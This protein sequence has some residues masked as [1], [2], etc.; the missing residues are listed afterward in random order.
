MQGDRAVQSIPKLK[1]IEDPKLLKRIRHNGYNR[2]QICG[3]R[4][5]QTHHLQSVGARGNDES[6]NIIRLCF[7]CHTQAHS[8]EIDKEKLHELALKR[9]REE[10][11]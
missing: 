7:K 5:S 1:R 11:V 6:T 9:I 10:G 8:G 3:A 2:C 4:P